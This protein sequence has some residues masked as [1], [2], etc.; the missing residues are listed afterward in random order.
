MS[1]ASSL[2]AAGATRGSPAKSSTVKAPSPSQSYSAQPS[3][4]GQLC[5]VQR[6]LAAQARLAPADAGVEDRDPHVG[7]AGGALP[8]AVRAHAGDLAERVAAGLRVLLLLAGGVERVL[9]EGGV[10]GGVRSEAE[11]LVLLVEDVR[12]VRA[13]LVVGLAVVEVRVVRRVEAHRLV[14]VRARERRLRS[15]RRGERQRGGERR[16]PPVNAHV[17]HGTPRARFARRFELRLGKEVGEPARASLPTR[18]GGLTRPET[19]STPPLAS[20][21]PLRPAPPPPYPAAVDVSPGGG[22]YFCPIP[23]SKTT[24][25][26]EAPTSPRSRST[27]TAASAAPL[28]G[29]T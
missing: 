29:A 15:R 4:F 10:L 24:T 27:R 13:L 12:A 8:G 3:G 20:E 18:A 6:D 9:V 23:Q 7:A 14:R 21:W 28:S 1:S 26:S 22:G 19:D 11:A 2:P 17:Q 16:D 5:A 25:L